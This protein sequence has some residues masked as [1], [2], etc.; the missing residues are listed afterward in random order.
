M[1]GPVTINDVQ[2][3]VDPLKGYQFQMT[4]SP[5]RGGISSQIL[6][7]RCTATELPGI[8]LDQVPI[9][10]AG[11]TLVYGGRIRFSHTWRTTLVEGTNS[12]IRIAIASWMKTAYNWI[13]GVG[14]NKTEIQ[15]TAKIQMYDNPNNPIVA[16]YLY[17]LFPIANP[18]IALQMAQST[19]VAP[20]ITW[21]F[22]YCDM[23][24]IAGQGLTATG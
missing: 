16:N 8:A 15:S 17:G 23:D 10:L 13:T 24:A 14:A 20:D 3:L 19:A 22:D 6:S 11:F 1:A 12:E 9:D 5:A 18:A 4:I 7:L 21:S 2:G